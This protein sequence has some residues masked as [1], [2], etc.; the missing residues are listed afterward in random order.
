MG[1]AVKRNH[2]R[3]Q[4]QGPK[5]KDVIE[6]LNGGP[7]P[8]IKFFF[9]DEI[10]IGGRKVRALRHGMAARR[11]WKSGVP[12]TST[13]RSATSSWKRARNSA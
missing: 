9:M 6:K 3:F 10:N 5:A 4:I 2:Y 7:I 11:A 13:W 8:E 12:T 1:R